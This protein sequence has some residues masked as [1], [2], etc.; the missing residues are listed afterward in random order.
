MTAWLRK[1]GYVAENEEGAQ[2]ITDEG[3][4]F[5]ESSQTEVAPA[6]RQAGPRGARRRGG[7][8]NA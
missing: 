4:A 6:P 7:N 1:R 2:E 3:V 5:L 8:R